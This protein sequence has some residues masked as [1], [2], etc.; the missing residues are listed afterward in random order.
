MPTSKPKRCAKS[1]APHVLKFR[2]LLPDALLLRWP[3]GCKGTK[4]KWGHLST[5]DMND[6]YLRRL[7]TGNIGVATGAISNHLVS[8]DVDSAGFLD[9]F[10]EHNPAFRSTLISMGRR[11]GNVWLRMSGP[12]PKCFFI[13]RGSGEDNKWGE[14]RSGPNTQTIIY[15]KH[16]KAGMYRLLNEAIPITTTY[17]NIKWP[18]GLWGSGIGEPSLTLHREADEAD[19]S[20][21]VLRGVCVY[22]PGPSR[23]FTLDE[24]VDRC[25]PGGEG[26]NH[27]LLHE[28]NRGIATLQIQ[29]GVIYGNGKRRE[30]FDLWYPKALAT[31]FLK[32]NQSRGEYFIEFM[33][34]NNVRVPLGAGEHLAKAVAQARSEAEP[35]EAAQ[36]ADSP[37]IRLLVGICFQLQK[38]SGTEPFYL[39]A[40]KAAELLNVTWKSCANWLKWLCTLEILE[41]VSKGGG[42]TNPREASRYRYRALSV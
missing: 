20:D 27:R 25:I 30:V 2:S 22:S 11:G 7:G 38:M 21:E 31:G 29:E 8:V 24:V 23:V 16:P 40:R 33:C 41:L 18:A 15:G 36:F 1:I 3:W 17:E 6:A 14:F 19:E 4:K 26:Y 34:S 39:S 10:L 42:K 37:N 28:L 12:Y 32:A 35:P 9:E 5:A 13:K